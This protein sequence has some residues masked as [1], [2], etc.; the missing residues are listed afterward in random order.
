MKQIIDI[1]RNIRALIA[2]FLQDFFDTLADGLDV[3]H[4]VG[5]MLV[6]QM[7][8]EADEVDGSLERFARIEVVSYGRQQILRVV[9]RRCGLGVHR[10]QP[11]VFQCL[12][13]R[14]AFCRVNRQAA[15]DK[16]LGCEQIALDV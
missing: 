2:I 15:T 14:H 4:R 12:V 3:R 7:L 13:R 11:R 9:G 10:R 16:V 8:G 5:R 1:R 6:A